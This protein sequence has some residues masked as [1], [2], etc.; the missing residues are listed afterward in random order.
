MT[1]PYKPIRQDHPIFE[2]DGW[3]SWGGCGFLGLHELPPALSRWFLC[4]WTQAVVEAFEQREKFSL[5]QAPQWTEARARYHE[6]IKATF[7][8]ILGNSKEDAIRFLSARHELLKSHEAHRFREIYGIVRLVVENEPARSIM[9]MVHG[10]LMAEPVFQRAWFQPSGECA[11][12][13]LQWL[14]RAWNMCG[15]RTLWLIHEDKCP[16]PWE[17]PAPCRERDGM[18]NK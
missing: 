10:G 13:R 3:R 17:T 6:A 7:L 11:F 4:E 18:L 9:L 12:A 5:M 1:A 15:E 14:C 2:M 8:S 16:L